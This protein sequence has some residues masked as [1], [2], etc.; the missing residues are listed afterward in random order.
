MYEE[1]NKSLDIE[2]V[3]LSRYRYKGPDVTRA[4][5]QALIY[6]KLHVHRMNHLK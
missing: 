6:N 2:D 3:A 1:H 4:L 5:A